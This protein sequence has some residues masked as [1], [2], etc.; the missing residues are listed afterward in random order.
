MNVGSL[1]ARAARRLSDAQSDLFVLGHARLQGF[2]HRLALGNEVI[3]GEPSRLDRR[4]ARRLVLGP[5]GPGSE[6][7]TSV[8]IDELLGAT[9]W[10]G[11]DES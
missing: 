9:D 10:P 6:S 2:G 3:E 11:P 1:G 4:Q 8:R 7:E 5:M